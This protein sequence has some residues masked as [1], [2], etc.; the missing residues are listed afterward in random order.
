MLGEQTNRHKS[1]LALQP[2]TPCNA[3]GCPCH[4][5]NLHYPASNDPPIEGLLADAHFAED[6]RDRCSRLSL[7]ERRKD[8]LRCV[9]GLLCDM[10]PVSSSRI[11]PQN[12]H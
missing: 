7:P 11:F 8:P 5:V 3:I 1:A 10:R 6:P 9:A 4:L 2:T 12:R